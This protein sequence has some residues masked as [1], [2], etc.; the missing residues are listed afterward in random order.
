MEGAIHLVI[1]TVLVCLAV[2]SL[3][4]AVMDRRFPLVALVVFC[5]GAGLVLTVAVG[6]HGGV[7]SDVEGAASFA[8]DTL[9]AV[10]L[11]VPH[12]FVEVAGQVIGGIY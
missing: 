11:L 6:R 2:P 9:P 5:A 7:P 1:G 3:V 10:L 4:S 8:A 12:A